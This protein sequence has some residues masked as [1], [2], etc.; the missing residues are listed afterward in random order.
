M[1]SSICT[2]T[3]YIYNYICV[4]KPSVAPEATSEGLNFTN[5]LGEAPQE[6]FASHDWV[7]FR[8]VYYW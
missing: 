3:M 1:H 4:Y 7:K 8:F 6:Q 2:C 5:F